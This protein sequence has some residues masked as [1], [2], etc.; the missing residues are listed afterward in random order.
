MQLNKTHWGESRR[1][2][3]AELLKKGVLHD[4]LTHLVLAGLPKGAPNIAPND[5]VG[6]ALQNKEREGYFEFY[7]QLFALAEAPPLPPTP[8][9]EPYSHVGKK[10]AKA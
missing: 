8:L 9:P 7:R 4:A 3:L 10:A 6:N 1:T 5:A 2:E